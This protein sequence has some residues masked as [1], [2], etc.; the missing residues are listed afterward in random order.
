MSSAQSF[1]LPVDQN[2]REEKL[3]HVQHGNYHAQF[4]THITILY[5]GQKIQINLDQKFF[6]VVNH[7]YCGDYRAVMIMSHKHLKL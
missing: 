7:V 4:C 6:M 1:T 5:R 3:E 2:H